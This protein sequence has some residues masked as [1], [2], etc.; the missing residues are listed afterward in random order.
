MKTLP[1]VFIIESLDPDDEGNGRCE[2]VMISHILRLHGKNPK[3][4]YVRTRAEFEKAIDEFGRSRY[5]YLHISAHGNQEGLCTTNQEE[6]DFDELGDLL[7][8]HLEGRRLFLSS[9]EMVH[10]ELAAEIIPKSGCFSVIGPTVKISFSD[11][12]VVWASIY[13]LMFS[14]NSKVMKRAELEQQ[15]KKVFA[16]FEVPLAFFSKTKAE[17]GYAENLVQ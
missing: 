14:R 4:H 11:A 17:P 3:Y 13:H 9:C 6:I 15:L 8:P 1:E 12:V 10:K 16:L 7:Q 5:R 2:G